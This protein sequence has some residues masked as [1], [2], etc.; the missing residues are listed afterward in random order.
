M[1]TI[2]SYATLAEFKAWKEIDGVNI[3][4][5]SDL[6]LI[7]ENASRYLDDMTGRTFYPR[8]ETQSYSVPPGR[9]LKLDDDLL[10]VLSITNG[11]D[12]TL[13]NTEYH[14]LPKNMSPKYM[15]D[16]KN[17][18]IYSWQYDTDAG[19][20]YVIDVN[21]V[22]G[23]HN[24]YSTGAWKSAGTLGAAI[25][26]TTGTSVTMTAGHTLKASKIYKVDNEIFIPS[27]V[28]NNTITL[29]ERG[30]N[31]STA[32]THSNGATVYEWQVMREI[33]KFCLE[34]TRFDYARRFGESPAFGAT[35]TAAGVVMSPK[36]MSKA[37]EDLIKVFRKRS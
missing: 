19:G 2:N 20:E 29:Y 14:T 12:T 5:D 23:F 15:I 35:I 32:A 26:D 22:W 17:T 37:E 28:A 18:S 9:S 34:K 21:A 6:E 33:K 1:T 10:E 3:Q 36:D 13:A 16:I 27:G 30:M 11:D 8:I 7:L 4:R 31:G 24:R 25:S